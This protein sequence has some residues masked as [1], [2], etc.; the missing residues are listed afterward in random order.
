MIFV[1]AL[2]LKSVEEVTFEG[3]IAE[4]NAAEKGGRDYL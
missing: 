4:M 1:Y 3:R 2:R